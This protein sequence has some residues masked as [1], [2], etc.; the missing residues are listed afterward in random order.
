[1]AT[2]VNTSVAAATAP[3]EK[4]P[5]LLPLPGCDIAARAEPA[6]QALGAPEGAHRGEESQTH[7]LSRLRM[8]AC[9]L[10]RLI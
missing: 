1:M 2:A 4:A 3:A 9:N 5:K 10:Q 6:R 7:R 8:H